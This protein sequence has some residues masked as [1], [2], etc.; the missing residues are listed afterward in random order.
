MCVGRVMHA[1]T[2]EQ[3]SRG[4]GVPLKT[5]GHHSTTVSGHVLIHDMQTP[6]PQKLSYWVFVPK[7]CAIFWNPWKKTIFW[8]LQS[9]F[10]CWYCTQKSKW[11]GS[12]RFLQIW[13]IIEKIF[14]STFHLCPMF[15]A[16]E[17]LTYSPQKKSLDLAHYKSMI[18]LIFAM[19]WEISMK[20]I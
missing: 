6:L 13:I 16:V 9:Y 1:L 19:F 5:L 10:F 20:K 18:G 14:F 11:I 12:Y 4:I 2:G 15:S 17:K 3:L 7:S 8:F